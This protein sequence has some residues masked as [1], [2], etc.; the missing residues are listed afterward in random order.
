MLCCHSCWH[1]NQYKLWWAIWHYL[2]KFKVYL[3][4][5]LLGIYPTCTKM[6]VC[7]ICSCE[8]LR[9]TQISIQGRMV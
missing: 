4:I 9:R 8:K 2:L 7:I 1:V 6:F 3:A 5:S